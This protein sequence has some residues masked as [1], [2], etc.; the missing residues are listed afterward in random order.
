[1]TGTPYMDADPTGAIVGLSLGTTRDQLIKAIIEGITYEM[2]LNMVLMKEAGIQIDELRAIGG[3]AKSEKWLQLKADMFDTKVVKLS[4]SE[5][6]CLGVAMAAGVANGDYGSFPEA[7]SRVVKPE[8]TYLPDAGRAAVYDTKLA[9]YR[10]LY[11]T[12]KQWKTG[13]TA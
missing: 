1:M 7:V 12:I 5:A 9:K 10:E 4:V 2:K 11:P 6:A 8:K 13:A 3:G